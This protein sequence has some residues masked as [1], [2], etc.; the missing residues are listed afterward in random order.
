[1][2]DGQTDT[3][4]DVYKQIA[5]ADPQDAQALMRMS[6]I[7]RRTGK[8]SEALGVLK[9]ASGLVEDSLEIPYNMALVYEAKGDYANA[10]QLLQQLVKRTEKVGT[11]TQGDRNN[12]AVFLERLGSIYREQNKTQLAVET[13]QTMADLG[14]DNASRGYMQIVEAYRDAKQWQKAADVAREAAQK[15]PNDRQVKITLASQL[16]DLGK[17]DEAVTIMKSLL[18]NSKEDRETWIATA[19]IQSR[20]RRFADAEE[21]L[22][23]AD[24][25]SGPKEDHDYLEFVRGSILERE[26]KYEAAEQSF[27]RVVQ[28]DPHNAMAL[29]YLGYMLLDHSQ[30]YEEA[31]NF[32]K[33]AIQ[34]DPENGAYL[35]SLGW[36]YFK[37]GNYELAEENLRRATEKVGNDGTVQDHLAELYAKTGR[38]RQAAAHWDRALAEWNNAAPADVDPDDVARVQR[39]LESARVKLA[40]E[41]PAK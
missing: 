1:M 4:L 35:D 9:K 26:K 14:G 11:A 3:A 30:K 10:V 18:K 24:K 39:K 21:S 31:L 22:T 32:I 33:R 6:D 19:Q 36:A 20:M 13:F 34:L 12:R 7:Y 27:Q 16:A 15:F 28:S 40:K 23:Q 29:N 41:Q 8:F 5:D 25:L 37:L 2:Y 17:G 38:L